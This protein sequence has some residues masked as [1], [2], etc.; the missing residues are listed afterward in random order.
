[1]QTHCQTVRFQM[2]YELRFQSLA[3]PGSFYHFPCDAS[4]HVDLDAL[5]DGARQ[6]YL[7][8]RA[9]MG[10]EY[11]VPSVFALAGR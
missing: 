6:D 1:M 7:Y 11:A 10:R 8:A 2:N 3:D 4:G 5:S 9:M